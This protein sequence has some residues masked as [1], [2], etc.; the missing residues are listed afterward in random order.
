MMELKLKVNGNFYEL[1]V[2]PHALLADVLKKELGLIG[3]RD[4]GL[5]MSPIC[6]TK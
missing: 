6:W 1:E 4:S 3:K 2:E 5:G